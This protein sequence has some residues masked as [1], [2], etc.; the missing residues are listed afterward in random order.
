[1]SSR[2]PSFFVFGENVFRITQEA[3]NKA[4]AWWLARAFSQTHREWS[5]RMLHDMRHFHP[6]P[7]GQTTGDSLRVIPLLELISKCCELLLLV[8]DPVVHVLLKYWQKQ[9]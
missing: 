7:H 5:L 8:V 2:E 4:V 6:D 1:M 3:E 9:G